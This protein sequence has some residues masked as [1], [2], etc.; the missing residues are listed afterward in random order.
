MDDFKPTKQWAL[1][2]GLLGGFGLACTVV[3]IRLIGDTW[4]AFAVMVVVDLL[5]LRLYR[6][7][8]GDSVLPETPFDQ[9]VRTVVLGIGPAL[10]LILLLVYMPA[11]RDA[12]ATI[13]GLYG[14]ALL[15]TIVIV[16]WRWKDELDR[17]LRG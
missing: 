13:A 15:A 17:W 5:A 16:W 12:K 7:K 14:V 11:G 8:W 4:L 2:A 9:M 6:S 10:P 3:T 1:H